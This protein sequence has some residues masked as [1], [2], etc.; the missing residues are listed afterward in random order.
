MRAFVSGS[1]GTI[2]RARFILGGNARQ[3]TR[4]VGRISSQWRTVA[5]FYQPLTATA[6]N[7]RGNGR[8]DSPILITANSQAVPSNGVPPYSY[9]WTI[10]SVTAGPTPTLFNANMATVA[11]Q[12]SV[13]PSTTYTGTL[14]VVVTDSQGATF[15]VVVEYSLTNRP[16][17][18]GL[19]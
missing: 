19:E 11:V 2:G 10:N 12:T 16:P 7:A 4:A 13:P 8:S 15:V 1:W 5:S 14:R 18:G 3:V 17:T 9:A 6:G